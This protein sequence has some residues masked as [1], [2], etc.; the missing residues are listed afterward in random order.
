MRAWDRFRFRLHL[1]RRAPGFTQQQ[2]FLKCL[3]RAVVVA[4]EVKA[5]RHLTIPE[6][7]A[8]ALDFVQWVPADRMMT[9]PVRQIHIYLEH[10]NWERLLESPQEART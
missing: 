6:A 7:G 8:V 2:R 10:E 1:F 9:E 4:A 5:E 3:L